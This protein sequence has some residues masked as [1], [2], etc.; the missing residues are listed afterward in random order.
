MIET[1]RPDLTDNQD[2]N[3]HPAIPGSLLI[4][5]FRRTAE[6][7]LM[8]LVSAAGPGTRGA[9]VRGATVPGGVARLRLGAAALHPPPDAQK[10]V[11]KLLIMVVLLAAAGAGCGTRQHGES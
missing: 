1:S 11:K 8:T 10:R 9:G 3:S 2:H 5:R 4:L 7:Q 6:Y